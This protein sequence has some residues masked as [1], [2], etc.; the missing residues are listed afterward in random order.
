MLSMHDL[1]ATARFLPGESI[2]VYVFLT[3][4]GLPAKQMYILGPDICRLL[5]DPPTAPLADPQRGI[6][7]RE[8][9]IIRI[10]SAQTWFRTR[11]CGWLPSALKELRCHGGNGW[12]GAVRPSWNKVAHRYFLPSSLVPSTPIRRK[13]M[14]WVWLDHVTLA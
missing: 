3:H 8:T 7:Q 11:K 6:P 1:K 4:I 13:E 12:A 10:V 9:H 2:H 5:I 14:A